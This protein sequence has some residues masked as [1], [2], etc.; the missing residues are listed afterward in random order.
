M[1]LVV[2][3][4][5]RGLLSLIE[6]VVSEMEEE[7]N[8]LKC[9][10]SSSLRKVISSTDIDLLIIDYWLKQDT[11]DEVIKEIKTKHPQLPIILMSAITNLPKVS[12]DLQ[13]ADYLKKPFE[14][15]LFKTKV[16]NFLNGTKDS[17][18]RR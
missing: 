2:C 4:D 17:N 9:T 1:N 10:D 8:L 14:V 11:A 5:D 16:N 13:V 6:L 3:E 12:A 18:N 15:E 7:I